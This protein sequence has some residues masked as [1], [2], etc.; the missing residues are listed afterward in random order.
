MPR[1]DLIKETNTE[2]SPR[3]AALAELFDDTLCA[4]VSIPD[5]YTVITD[6]LNAVVLITSLLLLTPAAGCSSDQVPPKRL[7]AWNR[8]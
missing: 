5:N 6:I 1:G 7:L 4:M 3:L 2:D 8:L